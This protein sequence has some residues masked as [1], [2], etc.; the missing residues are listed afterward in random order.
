MLDKLKRAALNFPPYLLII[1]F[2]KP[3]FFDEIWPLDLAYNGLRGLAFLCALAKLFFLKKEPR[4]FRLLILLQAWLLVATVIG[5]GS[6]Y[7]YVKTFFAFAVYIIVFLSLG[8]FKKLIGLCFRFSEIYTYLNLLTIFLFPAGL[9]HREYIGNSACWFLGQKNE[10]FFFFLVFALTAVYYE[11]YGGK[12][13]RAWS[14]HIAILVTLFATKAAGGLVS[15][16][17]FYVLWL[18]VLPAAGKKLSFDRLMMVDAAFSVL[19]IFLPDNSLFSSFSETVLHRSATFSGRVP[20]WK[21]MLELLQNRW[22]I[23]YGSLTSGQTAEKLGI[24]YGVSA[25]NTL[26]HVLFS[27]GVIYLVLFFMFLRSVSRPIQRN[28]G[29]IGRLLTASWFALFLFCAFETQ[30]NPLVFVL[31]SITENLVSIPAEGQL[32]ELPVQRVIQTWFH[33][34]KTG[35]K[36]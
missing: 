25:H 18:L 36:K 8:E 1:P 11:Q 22:L 33:H 26:L 4:S 16:L 34:F 12:S 9:Y 31:Y 6:I 32:A 21:K 15:M 14:L 19:V 35:K 17:A 20:I 5:R 24:Y 23:G 10:Q 7:A 29:P 27:G 3:G 13:R 2:F 28:N 30:Y